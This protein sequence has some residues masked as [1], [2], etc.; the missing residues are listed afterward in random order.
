MKRIIDKIIDVLEK[1][2]IVTVEYEELE[3]ENGRD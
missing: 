2:H 1:A 3:E